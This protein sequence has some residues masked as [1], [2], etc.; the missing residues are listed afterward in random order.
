MDGHL[1][2]VFGQDSG[3][4][5]KS[6]AR[7]RQIS[8]YEGHILRRG[9]VHSVPRDAGGGSHHL[10]DAAAVLQAE[11]TQPKEVGWVPQQVYNLM[12]QTAID[13]LL[14]AEHWRAY[15]HPELKYRKLKVL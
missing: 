14:D 10:C 6:L 12:I 2:T 7:D 15:A 11:A 1:P 13:T 9:D 4:H 8:K 3:T 5:L